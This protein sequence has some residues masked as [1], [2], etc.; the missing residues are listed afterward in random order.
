[1]MFLHTENRYWLSDRYRYR[2]DDFEAADIGFDVWQPERVP[3]LYP[4]SKATII[5]FV[6][7]YFGPLFTIQL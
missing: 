5:I 6:K 3:M 4:L 7:I 2:C 1:M